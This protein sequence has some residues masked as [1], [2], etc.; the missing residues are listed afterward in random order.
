MADERPRSA[1]MP[2]STAMIERL[3]AFDTTSRN[4]NL[5]MIDFV[6]DHLAE[7]GVESRLTH[8][9]EG[10]KANLYATLGP[11]DRPGI[12]LSGHTDVVPVDGQ[13]WE[14]DPFRATIREGRVYGRGTADMKS[15]I[16]AALTFAPDI[17]ARV[18]DT[19]VHFAFSYDEEL[20][21]LGAPR[22][23]AAI[24]RMPV[25]PAMCIIGEPTGMK[26]VTGHKGKRDLRCRVRGRECHSAYIHEGV[27][28]VEIAAELVAIL[29][30]MA[31]RLQR[32]GPFEAAFDPPFTTVHVGTIAG[33]TALN[34]VPRD[35]TFE[36]EI[37][38]LPGHDP[39]PLIEEVRAFAE[40][41]L[42]PRMREVAVESGIE[43]QQRGAYPGLATG[44]DGEVVRL[45][46]RLA[47]ANDTATVSFGTEGGLFDAAGIPAVVCG[48]GHIA[49]AHKANEFISLKQVAA[50]EDF[51]GRLLD[52][53][54]G[55]GAG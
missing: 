18:K 20:G 36:F 38:N 5:E 48:P 14:T 8:D 24:E 55:D 16:A 10:A 41:E 40:A 30:R 51:L 28:A 15:F 4:S 43:W 12:C 13:D 47:R 42:L 34:I 19:P 2:R 3:V 45:A 26:V 25:R 46:K 17:L 32:E 6:R 11:G 7:L 54:G 49:Q 31:Q 33:G 1:A 35:C 27:N 39:E 44:D 53:I 23:I 29:G 22:L 21:C 50:C 52:E 37:R 9:D